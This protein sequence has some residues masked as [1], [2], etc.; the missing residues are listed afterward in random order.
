[1]PDHASEVRLRVRYAETDQMGF[2]YYG[3]YAAWLEVGRVEFLRERGLSYREVEAAG[4]LLA[5]RELHLDYL[6]PARYDDLLSIRTRV[7][8]RTKSRV[9]F[10][11]EILMVVGEPQPATDHRPPKNGLLARGRVV[12]VCLDRSGR[13]QR[14]SDELVKA[15]AAS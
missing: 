11:S 9:A 2:A 15:C 12:L 13:P 10:Q 7:A 6:A 5:D 1:M 8:E 3:A 14:L 4:Q